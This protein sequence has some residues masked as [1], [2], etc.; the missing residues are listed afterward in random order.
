MLSFGVVLV[1]VGVASFLLP[2]V[3]MDLVF[4]DSIDAYQPWLGIIV[5]AVGLITVLY[6]GGRRDKAQTQT[7]VVNEAPPAS[8]PADS[9]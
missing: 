1:I 3:G 8:P 9:D 2:M 5:A 6:G 4:L 7:T